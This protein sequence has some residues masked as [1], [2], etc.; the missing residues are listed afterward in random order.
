VL[1]QVEFLSEGTTVRGDLYLPDGPGPFPIVVMAGGW[2]YVKELVQPSYAEA[3]VRAGC[4]AHVFDYRN[5]GDS[6]GSERQHLDPWSQIA[7]YRNAISFVETL[8]KID[9]ERVGVWGISYSGG[10]A[11][12]VGATDPRVRCIVSTIPV[13]DGLMTIQKV[14]GAIGFRRLTDLLMEDRRKR[15]VSQA[16]SYIPMSSPD[17]S[18]EVV[19]WPFPEVTE[20]FAKLQATD[21]P[22]HEH[23]NTVASVE[24]LLNY[25][26]FPYVSRILN[27][28]TLMIV[29]EGDDITLWEREIAAYNAIP[30]AKKRLFVVDHT[31]HMV[32]Y[33]NQSQLEIAADQGARWLGEHLVQPFQSADVS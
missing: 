14:H 19:T 11:L 27:T 18:N 29:A 21:A 9:G 2:C 28:P 4:A 31:T 25:T 1:T 26:V 15:F 33:S 5:L 32:L 20:V 8:D 12:I 10:H 16:H 7:D 22:N 17:F 6:D 13:V 23:R 24:A 3:F 30:T